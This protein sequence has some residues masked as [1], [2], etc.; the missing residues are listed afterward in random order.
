MHRAT[1]LPGL[2]RGGVR[3]AIPWAS[4]LLVSSAL[5]YAM[6]A[7]ITGG[8][9]ASGSQVGRDSA[10]TPLTELSP[11]DSRNF[12]IADRHDR[13]ASFP[14]RDTRQSDR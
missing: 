14:S 8:V 9:L 13:Y 10:A 12:R 3:S 7:A 5:A 1:V 6:N 4:V 2:L 11:A